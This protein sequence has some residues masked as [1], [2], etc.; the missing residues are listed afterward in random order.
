MKRDLQKA[1][2]DY[3]KRYYNSRSNEGAFYA[4]DFYQIKEISGGGYDA[5]TLYNAIGNALEAGFMIGY[6]KAQ[7]DYKKRNAK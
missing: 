1:V 6:R 3:Q 5:R 4:S 7:R 2:Q